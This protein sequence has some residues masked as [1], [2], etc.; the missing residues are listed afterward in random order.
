VLDGIRIN[1]PFYLA[2]LNVPKSAATKRYTL[3]VSEYEKTHDITFSLTVHANLQF[4]LNPLDADLTIKKRIKG[5]WK[6]GNAGGRVLNIHGYL[7]KFR[8]FG[9]NF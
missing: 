5:E 9:R 4:K 6:A 2:K 1:S 7:P 3:V 8:F